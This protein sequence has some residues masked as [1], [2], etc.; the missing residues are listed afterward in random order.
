M[1]NPVQASPL[2]IHVMPATEIVFVDAAVPDASTLLEQLDP[3][4]EVVFLPSGQDGVAFMAQQLANRTNI[5]ALHVVSHGGQGQIRLGSTIIDQTNVAGYSKEFKQIGASLL[6][7]GDILIYGCDV[8]RDSRGDA[9]IRQLAQLTSADVAASSNATGAAAK[10]AD[11]AL[12]SGYGDIQTQIPFSAKARQLYASR[13][14]SGSMN[15]SGV[16]NGDFLGTTV[17]DG[18]ANSAD[19]PGVVI[20]IYAANLGTDTNT[21]EHWEFW[22]DIANNG[23]DEIDDGVVPDAGDAASTV[24]RTQGGEDFSFEGIRVVNYLGAHTHIKFEGFRDGVSTGSETLAIDNSVSF[25]NDYTQLNGLT[26]AKFQNVDQI[27]ITDG[28]NQ[29]MYVSLDEL[30]FADAVVPP[31]TITSATYNAN[32]GTLVVTGT[33][34]TATG[35]ATND[36]VA[37]KFTMNG[38]GGSTY[39]LTDT[40]NVEISSATALTLTLSATD[41]AAVNLIVNKNGTSSTGGTT[42]NLAGA[43]GFIADSAATADLTGNGI[44]VS[45][46]AVPA[47]TSA[48]YDASTGVLTVTGSGLKMASGASNDIVA[49]KFTLTGEGG[50][51]YTLTDT[52]NVEISSGTGFALTFSATDRSAINQMLNKNGTSSTGATT[53]NL[54]AAE[55]W[56]AGADAAVMIADLTGNGITVSNV[57]VPTVTSATYNAATGALVVTGA[58]FLK[59]AGAT[60]DVVANKFTLTGE[61]AATYS[62]TDTADVEITSG[63]SFTLTLS[64]TDRN[65]VNLILNKNGTSSVDAT[66]YNLAAAEDWTAGADAAVVVADLTGNG[67]TTSNALSAPDAP[68]IGAAT[69]GDGQVSVA[70][71]AP[72]SNGGAAITG[73]TVTSNPGGISAGG[74]GFTT[75]PIAVT[76]LTNGTAYTFTVTA[77]NAIGTSVASGASASATPKGDQTIT[78][79]NPGA[80]NFGTTPDLGPTASASSTLAVSFSSSTTGVCTIT[81]TGTLTFVTAGSCS[82]DADQAGNSAWNAATTVSRTFTVNAIVPGAP[83]IGTATAG[84]TEA[85]VTFTAPVSTGGAAIIASG[86][87]VTA[88]PGGATATGSSSPVTVTGLTNG[89]AYTFTVTATNSAGE[90]AA[91]AASNSV[92]PAAPQTITFNNPG[93]QN[94]G[95]TPTLTATSSAGGGY[96]VTFTS[97]TTGVCTITSGG[98]LTFVTAG[99]CTINADQA[100]DGSYLV[101]PQ[102]S[103][104]FTVSAV[105]PGAPTIG[106]ATAGDTQASVAF[107]AP[108]SIGGAA[109]TGYTVTANPGGLT[110]TGAN[111]PIIVTGLT[112][113]VAY[114]FTVTATNSAGTGS[115]SAASNS[116]TPAAAQTITFA[117]P[118]AQNFGTSPTLTATSDSGLTPTFTSSTTGVCT[119]TSIGVLTFVTAGTCTINADQAGNG[120]YLAATQ[121]SR[122][123]AVNAVLPG[124][125]VIGTATAGNASASVAFTAPASNGGAAITGYTVTSNPG[126]LTATGASSPV[127]VP[128]LTNGTA[129][130]FTVVAVNSVGTGAA[131]AASNAV[132]PELPNTAPVIS[133]S[134]ATT[135]V[136][137]T[138]YSFVPAASDADEQTLTFSISNQPA[139]ASFSTSSGA[140]TGVPGLADVGTISGIVISVTDGT[141]S[142]ALA[143]FSI[144]VQPANQSPVISGT[145]ATSVDVGTP[146]SFTPT[147]SDPDEGAVL[148]FSISNKP[149]WASFSTSSGALS[150]TPAS[151]DVGVTSG[152]VISVSDGTTSASLAAFNL[153]VVAVNVAPVATDSAASTEEDNQ[154]SLTLT[155]QDADGD[156]LNYEIA[157]QPVHGTATLQGDLLIY[158]PA[159]DFNGTDS[160]GFIAKDAE[161]SSNTA[162]ISLTVTAVNDQPIAA[163]DSFNLQRTSNNQYQLAV[164]ANDSDVDTDPLTIDGA[165]SSVGT[166]TF[167]AQGLTLT[168]PELYAGPVTLRYTVSDGKGGRGTANVSLIITGGD[169]TNLPVIT[170]PADIT[171]NATALFT[172]VPLGNAT[173]V[174]RNGRRLRVSLI[175]G[176]L[177]FEPGEHIVYW[178]ATDADGNT[179]TKAQKVSV[180]PLISLSKDQLVTEGNEVVVEVILNGT[181][182]S[183]PVSVPYSV[184]GSAGANDH[185]L[186]SGVAEISS[187]TSTSVRFNVLEDG[188]AD[189]PE[190]IDIT[191]DSSVNRGS[192]RSS[193]IVITEANIAPVVTLAVEQNNLNRL[194][195]SEGD[196]VVTVTATVTD[197]NTQD[198]LTGSWDFGRLENVTTA[199]TELSFDPAEQGPGLYQVS[200]TATDNGSPNLSTTSRVF[201]VVR[202]SLP[203]L[204]SSDVDGDLVPDNQEGFAD[205]DGDGIP[206]YQDA[207]SECNVMPTELLGQTEFVAEGE[208]GVCLRLGTVAA[209]TDAGGLKIENDAVDTDTSAVN[210]GGIFDFIAYGLPEQGKSYSL[211]LPQRLPVPANAIYRKF[212]DATGWKDFVSNGQNSVSS[213]QGERGYCPPPGDAAWTAGLTEGHWCVQVRVEDGGPNDADGIANSAIVDPGGVAVAISSNRL[214]VAVADQASTKENTAVVVNVLANDTDADG[215]S[216]TITQAVSGFGT[217]TILADQKL[218]Y[219][220]NTDFTGLDTVIYSVTDGKGGTASSQLVI[221]V[222]SNSAPVAVNDVAATNDKTA[223]VIAVL[224]NDTD[225][226]GNSLTVTAATAVQGTVSIEAGQ[227]LRY[228][229]KSGFDGVDTI[230]YSISDGL[231]GTATGQVLVTVTAFKE[232]VVENKS[233]G[234]SMTLWALLLLGTAAVFRRS[235][236]GAAAAVMLLF[237]PISQS[238]DWYLQGSAGHSSADSKQSS[239][240]A[241]LPSGTAITDFDKSDFSYGVALGYQLHPSVAIELGYQDL[242][243]ASSQ[244][245]G[246][247]LTPGQYHEL[248]KAVSPVLVDGVSAAFRFTLWQDNRLR[249]EL[250]VGV[251]FWD[252]E[253]ESRVNN[254]VLRTESDGNDWML[255]LQLQYQLTNDWQLGGGYQQIN[256]AAND[257]NS[258]L[259]SLR[260]QF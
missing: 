195:I 214:P 248:L 130:T 229:P 27:R 249:L 179:A 132:T 258:W 203:V 139:W 71:S 24:I 220:P 171:V 104:T 239:L 198:Q 247:S 36:V 58:G 57:A 215:D 42:Y 22:A 257:V 19:I 217:V 245:S 82:I 13:L 243:D 211:V 39:T 213:T 96:V 81:S 135:V 10:N 5:A 146:Y 101:A 167:N 138:P 260:Y 255:G 250:P 118:G 40:A 18:E 168:V 103:Q 259:L 70:F 102:V 48:T 228:T 254:T 100:G 192:K 74:F 226:D 16:A 246:E 123:F 66:T 97:A 56:Q 230:S 63:S 234:G 180:N 212:N 52:S 232:V 200:Y 199:D 233:S 133:G 129:Y 29:L 156:E 89:L 86:Y 6:Q 196:G 8:A 225:V 62:L 170:V 75:S 85:T 166:V 152:I 112:N 206:D 184:S 237:S 116:I 175:N 25:Y 65:A 205:S 183:Y 162:T 61:G 241:G 252:S 20:E 160:I 50:S 194:T 90:G 145:P 174:D 110:G 134:P 207:I 236:A 191:L 21:G 235:S 124:A 231:G 158:T 92:T 108:A 106:T 67:I 177:F 2:D 119:I 4:V 94:F 144:T 3:A 77:T 72:G 113:G 98:L 140:L 23:L 216:L 187:G 80:Q 14:F 87:T 88:S 64:A 188:L 59:L 121:V 34:F 83:T 73:Y 148:T 165:S 224:T 122:S 202:P 201:I 9:F 193:R 76:G 78:F 153:T 38:E 238:A 186:V 172:R 37:N 11:W 185:T 114:T 45:N 161:L 218:S 93:T 30:V 189:S 157:A 154:L 32:T 141:E 95:T 55:D 223:I 136:Q 1:L 79:P 197:T 149:A 219:L 12:E 49:N 176:S 210:I 69:A 208:P 128:G 181:A 17:T 209:E 240:A 54:A 251:F 182:P 107:T 137:G 190:N 26:P 253:I 151:A 68:T 178:Q 227:R 7:D 105:V 51:T 35:G 242:G 125:P 127:T 120:S 60:N 53:Y 131:S 43:A 222:F 169:A 221:D 31:P 46:V 44:T 155:A 41:R 84:D 173:A 111:S 115:A 204:G 15:F 143:P 47:V 164:L 126:G 91:S 99:S 109:I 147:A 244:L 33:N 28:S 142:A 159:Q 117:N 163:D 256:L 150:G